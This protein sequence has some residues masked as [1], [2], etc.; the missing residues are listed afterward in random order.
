[1]AAAARCPQTWSVRL[2]T[3]GQLPWRD[4]WQPVCREQ[5]HMV[6][7]QPPPRPCCSLV[8]DVVLGE[9]KDRIVRM[10]L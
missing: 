2:S 6:T 1:M 3:A 5:V 7:C 10:L 4:Q 9:V 8:T